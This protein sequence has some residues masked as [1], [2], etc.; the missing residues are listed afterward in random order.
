MS[1]LCELTI[2][3]ASRRLAAGDVTSAE[4]TDSCLARI[5]ATDGAIG[6]FL[7]VTADV[8]RAQAKAADERL[9]AKRDVT[10]LT[11]IPIAL[12]DLFITEGVR[13]TCASK[14]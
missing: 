7:T 13:T 10:P 2:E 4:L 8:A 1:A 6:S 14:I 3:E 11:G 5:E 9:R 12:K